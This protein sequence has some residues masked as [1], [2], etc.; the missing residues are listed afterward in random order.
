MRWHYNLVNQ[1]GGPLVRDSVIYAAS[2]LVAGEPLIA[3]AGATQCALQ[4]PSGAT[5]P[6]F[7]GVLAETPSSQASAITT[8]TLYF[9]KVIMNPDAIYIAQYGLSLTDIDVVSSTSTA[10]T[11]GTCDDNM[12]GGWLYV[13]SGTGV[14]QLAYVG[15]ASTTVFTLDTTTAWTTTPDST[16]DV[17]LIRPPWAL[18]L[19]LNSTDYTTLQ[20]DEDCTGLVMPLENYIES[21][22]IPFG[23]MRPR[24]HHMLQGLNGDGVRFYTDVR[25]IDNLFNKVVVF[26]S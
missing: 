25:F 22:S 3:I 12:D 10:T 9:G 4:A 8:G 5:I 19:D 6:D 15:A 11:L 7:V 17:I 14:G 20:T 23:P 18:N 24:Q 13:N 2:G 21:T 1:G 16:S 26:T